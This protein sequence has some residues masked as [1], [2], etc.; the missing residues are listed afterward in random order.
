M[1]NDITLYGEVD[2]VLLAVKRLRLNE[3]KDGYYVAFS[4]GKDSCVVLDLCKRAGVKYDAH[5]NVTTVDPPEVIKF[6]HENYK[7]VKFE[8]PPM[9]MYKL[10]EK[11]Q[12]LPTRIARYCC[13]V[14][15]ERGGAGR[16]V[17]T[18]IRREESPRRVKRH[19]V[20]PCRGSNG[21]SF[22]HP[23]IEWSTGDVWEYI[24]KY[25]IPYCSL[26]DEGSTRIGCVCCPFASK[27][28]KLSEKERWPQIFNNQ[29]KKGAELA[30]KKRQKE[31]KENFESPEAMLQ[32]WIEGRVNK[33]EETEINIF[34]LMLDE[35]AL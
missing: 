12:I 6:V 8:R 9:P 3:P 29:W 2:K 23:I 11:K 17:V 14:Y 34:G 30:W 22:I 15:K 31:K 20:E 16:T 24:R 5:F 35:T 13:A 18:G 4:G 32:W 27:K 33:E 19:M 1:L 7:E 10:I 26:Y 28:K 21:T 25:K